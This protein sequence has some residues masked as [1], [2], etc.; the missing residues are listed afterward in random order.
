MERKKPDLRTKS[1]SDCLLIGLD[2][3]TYQAVLGDISPTG[4]LIT[5]DKDTSHG[6]HEGEM[7][8]FMLRN[9]RTAPFAKHTGT[10]VTL[11]SGNVVISF[12]HQ[13][14]HYHNKKK[15]TSKASSL[16][17]KPLPTQDFL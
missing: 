9:K 14:H 16:P 4:A 7:C 15:F 2:G 6:L 13:E 3:V 12:N 5:M 1:D 17:T 10:I 8:G 11:D